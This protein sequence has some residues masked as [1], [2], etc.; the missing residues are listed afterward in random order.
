MSTR[1]ASVAKADPST[2]PVAVAPEQ[3]L[4]PDQVADERDVSPRR[5]ASTIGKRVRAIPSTLG[6]KGG[7]STTVEIRRTDFKLN[8]IDHPTVVWDFRRD[9]FTVPVV[10]DANKR[11]N[12]LSEEAARFLTQDH[13]HAFEF[14]NDG[15]EDE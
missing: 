1:T 6:V 14:I 9:N 8:S 11:K 7:R 4:S 5:K 2:S 13:K 15:T 10:A 12:T 3:T